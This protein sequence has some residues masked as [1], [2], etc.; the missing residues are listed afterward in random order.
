VKTKS[1]ITIGRIT[2][3]HGIVGEL[4]VQLQPE[5][6]GSLE[7]RHVR[8]IYLGDAAAPQQV[9]SARL[10]QE[11]LLLKLDGVADRNAAEALRGIEVHVDRRD[12][13]AL[14]DGE[15][16]ASDL[17]GMRILDMNG[18]EIGRLADGDAAGTLAAL[19]A[20]GSV[21][22]VEPSRPGI[23]QLT[24]EA[25][26]HGR[27]LVAAARAGD[28]E[29]ALSAQRTFQ[30]LCGHRDGPLG[31]A[32]WNSR[33]EQ[34]L[35]HDDGGWVVGRP[36]LVTRND[37]A[38][39]LFNGDMGLVMPSG[40]GRAVAVFGQPGAVV[41]VPVTRLEAVATVH[42]MTIHKSQGS[43]YGEVA[44]L[45]PPDPTH[46]VLSRELLYTAASRAKRAL[47]LH[48]DDRVID[49]CLARPVR[50]AGGLHMR[51][52]EALGPR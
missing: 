2:R 19:E 52:A 9:R 46:R 13:P 17:V 39:E 8:R 30:I 45:L 51:L 42:A 14:P 44:V 15:F 22:W 4:K 1:R 3:P 12:L 27:A 50:R 7:P 49:A 34:G 32:G 37:R 6:L 16:Y 10:H 20:G 28:A 48:A 21:R 24:A 26:A 5:Y 33:V 47:T 25:V 29:R 35:G 43:E 36:L 18:A 41:R 40:D 11:S 31:V 23:V 38:L